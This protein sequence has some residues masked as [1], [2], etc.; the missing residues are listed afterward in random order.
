MTK[1]KPL[2][3]SLREKKRYLAF[4]V[5]SNKKIGDFSHLSEAF[6]SECLSY[7]GTSGTADAGVWL[8][9]DMWD[10]KTQK[11]LIRINHKNVHNVKTAL[12]L[13]Q[14]INRQNVIVKSLGVSGILKKAKDRY[15]AG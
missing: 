1:M 10:E 11:G 7:L 13:M 14:K 12:T 9:A 15:L 4:E 3:P 8:L 5:I 2:L 6:W